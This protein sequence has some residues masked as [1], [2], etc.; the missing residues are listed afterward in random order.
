[1]ESDVIREM[2]VFI[3]TGTTPNIDKM[4]YDLLEA[5]DKYALDRLKVEREREDQQACQVMC[6]QALCTNLSVENACQVVIVADMHSA[7]QLKMHAVDFINVHA[8]DVMETEAWRELVQRHPHLLAEAFKALATQH[9]PPPLGMP[10]RKRPKSSTNSPSQA[11]R[12]P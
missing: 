9:T 4:A 12:S 10:P 6:E 5:A 7:E 3:Y 8:Q 1:M 11:P 2:L